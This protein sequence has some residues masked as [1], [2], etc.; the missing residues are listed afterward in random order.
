MT[1][2][3]QW[4]GVTLCIG[5]FFITS[6][7]LWIPRGIMAICIGLLMGKYIY[8]Q[9]EHH[10]LLFM[11]LP[12]I[13]VTFADIV[14]VGDH[15]ILLLAWAHTSTSTLFSQKQHSKIHLNKK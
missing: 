14:Y 2:W 8:K 12:S 7:R 3:S 9:M 15:W 6:G 5:V 11:W 4:G 13:N 10:K 1:S